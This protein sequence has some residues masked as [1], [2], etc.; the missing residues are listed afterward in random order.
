MAEFLRA[1][2]Y[3][4]FSSDGQREES[5]EAQVRAIKDFA[6]RNNYALHTIYTDRALSGT[7]DNRPEFIRMI[8]DAK[9]GAFDAIIVHKLDRFARNRADSAIYR[10]ELEKCGVKLISVL[11]NF[12]DSPE[13]IILQSVI[14]G[15][16][17]Y[18]SRNLRREVLKGLREN[19]LSCRFTGGTPPLGY[20]INRE[21]LKYEINSFEAEAV[22]LIFKMY[23]EGEGY[24]AIIDE[25]NRRS[26]TTKRG[27]PFGKN[28]IFEILKNEKYTG[29]YIYNKTAP[30]GS[31]GKWNRHQT[32]N[33]DEII[34]VEGGI[35]QIISKEDF[36]KVQ[37][38]MAERKHKS[39]S[40][41]AKQEYLLSGKI[42]CG[43]CGSN[44]CGNARKS[45]ENK[46]LY[47]SYN[48]VKK[49]G[50]VKCKN[51]GVK[52]DYIEQLVLD[53]LSTTVFNEEVLPTIISQYNEYA[54]SR[55]TE[56]TTIIKEL[57]QKIS[58]TE[59]GISNIVDIVVSTGSSALA[60]KLNELETT[61]QQ[62]LQTLMDTEGQVSK[63]TV[64]EKK[65]R[66]AFYKAKQMLKSGTLK[67]RKAIV[68]K[69]VKQITMYEDRIEIEYH[70]SDTYSFK[71][72]VSRK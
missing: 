38:K 70:I 13:S 27:K 11:E 25:L 17:E 52:R 6:E 7:N 66:A 61:K 35:P 23:L 41:K 9:S 10:R 51:P 18:Y 50:S 26:F 40:Y 65:L 60:D 63:L 15:Y 43:C 67:N 49:N 24:T 59:K 46:P 12:D 55:N 42:R 54:L 71:E 36:K 57:K 1:V 30:V 32:R 2:A 19:A 8:D 5:I 22:K 72:T 62:L 68:E 21:T 39:A 16:N 48:C 34:R 56:Y 37:E 29:T 64:D 20:K 47:I 28:S 58:D 31:D 69:Y 33:E 14:E 3:T 53:K 45:T 4:R 44:F